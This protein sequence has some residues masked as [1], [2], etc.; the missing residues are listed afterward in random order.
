MYYYSH[1]SGALLY[2]WMCSYYRIRCVSTKKT[3]LNENR[4]STGKNK[5]FAVSFLLL[6]WTSS[7]TAIG[8]IH[9]KRQIFPSCFYLHR[10]LYC[11]RSTALKDLNK[12]L[13][14][15]IQVTWPH[16][17]QSKQNRNSSG[18]QYYSSCIHSKLFPHTALHFYR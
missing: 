12:S 16:A 1:Y 18:V 9:T 13:H 14:A 6:H 15:D 7:S 5:M 4:W 2:I 17:S 10:I 3:I 11:D 8:L